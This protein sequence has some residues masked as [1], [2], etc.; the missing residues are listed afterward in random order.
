MP[1]TLVRKLSVAVC[2]GTCLASASA[3]QR[4]TMQVR[5]LLGDDLALALMDIGRIEQIA[6]GSLPWQIGILDR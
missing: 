3:L 1:A 4:V 5:S 6:A 2:T